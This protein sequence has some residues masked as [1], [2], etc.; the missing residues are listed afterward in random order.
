MSF[1]KG[2]SENSSFE[3]VHGRE[4]TAKLSQEEATKRM[5]RERPKVE[6]YKKLCN[7]VL[8][9]R[10]EK[11]YNQTYYNL[12]TELLEWNQEL[13]TVWNYRKELIVNFLFKDLNDLNPSDVEKKHKIFQ[14][15]LNFV[16]AKL[17]KSPK[18]YWIWNH[19][20]WCLK[21]D[22]L[23]NWKF[24]LQLIE[25]FLQVDSRNFHVWSYRRFII[26]CMKEDENIKESDEMIDFNEFKFTTKMINKD[27]SNYS[28]WHNRSQLIVKLFEKSPRIDK[29]I[30]KDDK[31]YEY[32]I[33]FNNKDLLTFL[34]TELK[35]VKTAIYTDPDD[36]SVWFYLKWIISDYFIDQ[37]S[38]KKDEVLD[39]IETL[40]SDVEELNE[41]EFDDNGIDNK[42]CLITIVDLLKHRYHL[43]KSN[44]DSVKFYELL[45]KLEV[46][47]PMRV[48]RYKIFKIDESY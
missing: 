36:S 32:L 19:R 10:K 13:Y 29:T 17:K 41:V 26:Q 28:A 38:D 47:D 31:L 24:E 34:K 3:S 16:L 44:E 45:R 35:L 25:T 39:I 18:S 21:H 40:L 20:M 22:K 4:R 8:T 2:Y 23:S 11:I 7:K 37:L 12:V 6:I 9:G 33:L 1:V 42:W 5:E 30:V 46:L 48:E 43:Q 14:D 15:E 27:I